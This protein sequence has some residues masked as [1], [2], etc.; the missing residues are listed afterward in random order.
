[1]KRFAYCMILLT[2]ALVGLST[3]DSKDGRFDIYW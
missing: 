3:A 1:M 2:T